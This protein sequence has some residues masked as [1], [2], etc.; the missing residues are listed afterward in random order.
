[1]V[2]VDVWASV[3]GWELCSTE[4]C[5][6]TQDGMNTLI[7]VRHQ[8]ARKPFQASSLVVLQ[9]RIGREKERERMEGGGG[10]E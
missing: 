10:V 4:G 6:C 5:Y 9:R 3:T 1:M 7:R 8:Q 2:T